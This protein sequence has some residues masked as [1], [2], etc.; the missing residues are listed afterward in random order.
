LIQRPHHGRRRT[1]G[2]EQAIP[3]YEVERHALFDHRLPVARAGLV[4][5]AHLD[6]A[7]RPPPLA[8]ELARGLADAVAAL[9]SASRSLRSR[10]WAQSLGIGRYGTDDLARALTACKGLGALAG[11][12]AVYAMCDFDAERQPLDGRHRY[13]Q[14]FE[15]GALP[16]ADGF[17]SVT[18]Y[19]ADRFLYANALGRHSLGDR[20]EGLKPDPDGGLT[21][22]VGHDRPAD[23]SNWLPAPPG[24]CYLVL[25]LYVPR[26]EARDWAIPP[27]RRVGA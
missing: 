22:V 21:L 18:L 4:A 19:G 26:P 13:V 20:T 3:G 27:L 11:E 17:W 12:D 1:G 15:P 9:E 6:A 24:A 7:A 10:P 8:D 25:R 16:P 2:R 23:A 5:S 14:R